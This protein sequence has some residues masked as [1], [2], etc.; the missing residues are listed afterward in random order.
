MAGT[1]QK[2]RSLGSL[3]SLTPAQIVVLLDF[4][5][6]FLHAFAPLREPKGG[7]GVLAKAIKAA[8][9]QG[10]TGAP[11]PAQPKALRTQQCGSWTT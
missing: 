3:I 6:H 10:R 9:N 11:L 1:R 8:L 5:D 4:A 7:Q 2:L